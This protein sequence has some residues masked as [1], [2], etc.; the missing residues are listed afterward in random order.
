[1]GKNLGQPQNDFKH[2][3][4][5]AFE[6]SLVI[7][8]LREGHWGS[9]KCGAASLNVNEIGCTRILDMGK[10]LKYLQNGFN[11]FLKALRE[12]PLSWRCFLTL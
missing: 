2:I 7:L 5:S 11:H 10:N 8:G 1:M 4:I 12:M 9:Q 3:I 6:V